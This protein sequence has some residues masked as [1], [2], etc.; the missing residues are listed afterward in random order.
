MGA[1]YYAKTVIGVRLP[2]NEEL[3][4]AKILTRKKAFDH[5]FDDDGKV[6]FHPKNGKKLWLDEK[7]RVD[8]DYPAYIFDLEFLG[9]DSYRYKLKGQT[10]IEFPEDLEIT[11][12]TNHNN[13]Y[14]GKI[15]ETESSNGGQNVV[16]EQVPDIDSIKKIIKECL[17]LFGLWDEERFGIYTILYCSY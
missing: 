17:E 16:F 6:E 5:D 9:A 1:D 7:E 3:P 2:R 13:D 15:I 12:D 11:Y 14:L 8:A 10:V 4:R